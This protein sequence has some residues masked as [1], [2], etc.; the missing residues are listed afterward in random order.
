MSGT[1]LIIGGTRGLGWEIAQVAHEHRVQPVVV[2]RKASLEPLLIGRGSVQQAIRREGATLASAKLAGEFM[3]R[4][5]ETLPRVT[6]LFYVA[7]LRLKG[8]LVK[9]S[10]GDI[11][12]VID[13]SI[14]G[15]I[16][17]L[18]TFL[19]RRGTQPFQLV[20]VAS[21]SAWKIRSDEAVYG[22]VNAARAQFA[23][24][25]HRELPPGS[26]TL[27]VHPGGMATGFWEGSGVD[28][29]SFLDPAAV[30]EVIWNEGL[31]QA[32]GRHP[33]LHELHIERDPHVQGAYLLTRGPRLPG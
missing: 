13:V 1:A 21:T 6:H 33:A 24:N 12:N 16:N 18:S 9:Q 2:G 22:M 8:P 10:P 25:I 23:R 32:A 28:T 19:E 15:I 31:D 20:V 3:D 11:A 27:I 5:K 7:G 26:K 14:R 4:L 30:A 17:T 29:A